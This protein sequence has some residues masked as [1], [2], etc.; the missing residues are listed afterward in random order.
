MTPR[1]QHHQERNHSKNNKTRSTHQVNNYSEWKQIVLTNHNPN[2][3]IKKWICRMQAHHLG[4]N[5]LLSLPEADGAPPLNIIINSPTS[6]ET[7][8][9]LENPYRRSAWR[10]PRQNENAHQS[11]ELQCLQIAQQKRNQLFTKYNTSDR[12]FMNGNRPGADAILQW[13][14]LTQPLPAHAQLLIQH[15]QITEEIAQ[16]RLFPTITQAELEGKLKAWR[17]S[18]TTSPCKTQV[19]LRSRGW[20]N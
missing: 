12:G 14:Y 4:G 7:D 8:S 15:L 13:H 17:E 10:E 2:Q 16:H 9:S 1:D 3:T 19:F 18:T 5:Q 6:T 11:T 20:W